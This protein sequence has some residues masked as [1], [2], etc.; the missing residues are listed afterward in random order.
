[1][2]KNTASKKFCPQTLI[3]FGGVAIGNGFNNDHGDLAAHDALEQAW[4]AGVRYFDTSPWYG[5][6]I[7]ERRMGLF[8]K[9]KLKEEYTISTKIG[10]VLVPQNNF[11]QE[12]LIWGGQ[13]NASYQ[14]DYSAQGARRSVEDSLQRMGIGSLDVVY[15]HDL[16]PDNS[17]MG[18]DWLQ[19]FETAKNG[20]FKELTKMR[21]E[22][23]IKGWGLGVNTI[24][25]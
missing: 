23:L 13:L 21:E 16:S 18:K 10:R 17:D 9:D 2:S 8:L 3:G 15:V 20:A 5:L 1:M 7:S 14:Y 6:G 24:E 12:G 11:K 25:P 22:G 19:Y 4:N